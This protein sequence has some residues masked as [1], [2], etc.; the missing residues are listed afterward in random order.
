MQLKTSFRTVLHV[1]QLKAN[2]LSHGCQ[3]KILTAFFNLIRTTQ[4]KYQLAYYKYADS[5]K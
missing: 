1:S 5:K 2:C 3:W 4:H